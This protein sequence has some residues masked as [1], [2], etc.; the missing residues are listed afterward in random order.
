MAADET[1][2]PK[3]EELLA[4]IKELKSRLKGNGNREYKSRLFSFIFGREEHKAWTLAL[5]NAINGTRHT[6][7]EDITINTIEEIGRAHV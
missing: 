6:N 2:S 3:Y 4:E 5:Y 7:P 1:K